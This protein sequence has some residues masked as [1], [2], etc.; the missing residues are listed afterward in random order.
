MFFSQINV[1]ASDINKVGTV[2]VY[3]I[4]EE[5]SELFNEDE[6]NFI[7]IGGYNSG[8]SGTGAI[9]LDGWEWNSSK[10][11][12]HV[13]NNVYIDNTIYTIQYMSTNYDGYTYE[14]DREKSEYHFDLS[15]ET[16]KT[17]RIYMKKYYWAINGATATCRGDADLN[18][19]VELA[20]LTVVAKY[21]LNN[22]VYPLANDTAYANA[23]M[24]GDGV[25][26]GLDTFAL[27]E[28]QLGK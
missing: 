2:T 4:D 27:I 1:T 12:P 13:L 15:A 3:V 28:N 17:V 16:N 5:T 6:T 7:M 14:I 20:D 23:D 22:E 24:N 21:N 26:D 11:N 19:L 10:S 18:G 8:E 9:C 25:V